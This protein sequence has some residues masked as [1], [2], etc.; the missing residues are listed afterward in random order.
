MIRKKPYGESVDWWQFGVLFFELLTGKPPFNEKDKKK[1]ITKIIKNE[2]AWSI[3]DDISEETVDLLKK[4][5]M[6]EP[7]N[8][9]EPKEIPFHQCFKKLDYEKIKARKAKPP[10]IPYVVEK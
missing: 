6:K 2:P 5:L 4:L 9:I 10:I 3:L 7:K 8:R 1:L